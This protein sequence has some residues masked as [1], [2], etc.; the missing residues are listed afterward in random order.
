[1]S[2][3]IPYSGGTGER[4][5]GGGLLMYMKDR[6]AFQVIIWKHANDVECMGLNVLLSPHMSFIVIGLYQPPT[7]D[8][9][10]YYHLNAMLKE[11]DQK[12]EIIWVISI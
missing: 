1:M 12:K 11:C 6:I 9:S 8:I 5:E 7:S 3:D 2:L 10:L 4:A